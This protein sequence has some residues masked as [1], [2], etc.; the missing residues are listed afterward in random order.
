[1]G[2]AA[3]LL[4]YGC[5]QK[6][7]GDTAIHLYYAVSSNSSGDTNSA[8]DSL[9]WTGEERDIEGIFSALCQPPDDPG[10]YSMIPQGT[11][12]QDWEMEEGCLSLDLS[13]EYAT[14]S[15][16]KLTIANYCIALTMTQLPQVTG[17]AITADGETMT[18]QPVLSAD[19]VMLSGGQGDSGQIS[20][21]LYFPKS[22][23][24]GLDCETR[25][26]EITEDQTV[27]QAI[28]AALTQGPESKELSAFLPESSGDITLWVEGEICYVNLTE[29]WVGALEE[30]EN[31]AASLRCVT[32]SLCQLDSVSAA[33]FLM[34]GAPIDSWQAVGADFPLYPG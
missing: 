18:D 27:P 1:V 21:Q 7:A 22:D 12:L 10:L 17:V 31:L 29:D 2:T 23:G 28:L 33:Q 5:G 20:A 30:G 19:Q 6:E 32:N 9:D 26:L 11:A 25:Q 13:G 16:V 3:A 24:T 14:L 15:G 34:D 4:L 8:L